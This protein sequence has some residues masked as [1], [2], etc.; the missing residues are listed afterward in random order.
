M[1][2]GRGQ[3]TTPGRCRD[4]RYIGFRRLPYTRCVPPFA[5]VFVAAAIM[6]V[7]F[8]AGERDTDVFPGDLTERWRRRR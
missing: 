2:S 8:A 4:V 3:S 1:Q 5:W 6:A 7:L